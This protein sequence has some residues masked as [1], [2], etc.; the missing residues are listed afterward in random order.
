MTI[1]K[2]T[3]QVSEVMFAKPGLDTLNIDVEL[4]IALSLT[5]EC[6]V[7]V[8]AVVMSLLLPT[9]IVMAR[10]APLFVTSRDQRPPGVVLANPR[11]TFVGVNKQDPALLSAYN[12]DKY[13]SMSAV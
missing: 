13:G 5:R 1:P 9:S 11:R 7:A 2:L 6:C 4:H 3:R 8:V 12:E 10:F